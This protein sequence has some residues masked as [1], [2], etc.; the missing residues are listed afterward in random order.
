MKCETMH[1]LRR[2]LMCDVERDNGGNIEP[3]LPLEE[4]DFAKH[5]GARIRESNGGRGDIL[6]LWQE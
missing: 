1:H 2:S 3:T 6:V 5:V 4:F